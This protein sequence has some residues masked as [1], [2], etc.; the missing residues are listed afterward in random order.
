MK[1]FH[2]L[3][4]SIMIQVASCKKND[5]VLK[6]NPLTACPENSECSFLFTENSDIHLSQ[7]TQGDYRVFKSVVQ[8]P[9]FSYKQESTL[10]IKAPMQSNEFL[11]RPDEIKNGSV[12][13][14]N[15]DI[16]VRNTADLKPIG[17]FVKGKNLNPGNPADQTKWL[18]EAELI[19]ATVEHNIPIDTLYL[20]QYFH[21]GFVY[22]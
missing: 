7:L 20:K 14:L 13:Y 2:L 6:D 3:S 16:L 10:W 9:F 21:P 12:R 4:L 19:M 17:G 5:L 11:L 1:L 15:S 8:T 22:N 18:I